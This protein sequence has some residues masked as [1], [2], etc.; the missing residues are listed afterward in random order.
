MPLN[1]MQLGLA[2]LQEEEEAA[3][4]GLDVDLTHHL[5]AGLLQDMHMRTP[6][7][8]TGSAAAA[9]LFKPKAA[10]AATATVA[11]APQH[12]RADGLFKAADVARPAPLLPSQRGA[13]ASPTRS[14]SASTSTS[15]A[16]SAPAAPASGSGDGAGLKSEATAAA[17]AAATRGKRAASPS[18]SDA[19]GVAEDQD[20][21]AAAS[22][23]NSSGGSSSGGSSVT[24]SEAASKSDPGLVGL[25]VSTSPAVVGIASFPQRTQAQQRKN[26]QRVQQAQ[27]PATAAPPPGTASDV[28]RLPSASASASAYASAAP[29][30]ASSAL[31]SPSPSPSAS[32]SLS[33]HSSFNRSRLAAAERA[34]HLQ[35]IATACERL[36]HLSNDTLSLERLRAGKLALRRE[37][38]PLAATVCDA[39][40]LLRAQASAKGVAIRMQLANELHAV[41]AAPAAGTSSASSAASLTPSPAAAPATAP[42][43]VPFVDVESACVLMD[44]GRI[45][46]AISNIVS[47]ALRF[48]E[49]GDAITVHCAL[50][51]LAAVPAALADA[52][53]S[54]GIRIDGFPAITQGLQGTDDGLNS[55]ISS[56]SSGACC[57][58]LLGRASR[59]VGLRRRRGGGAGT[60]ESAGNWL[61][62]A[63][64]TQTDGK[65]AGA[66]AAAAAADAT[67]A[68]VGRPVQVIVSVTD[69]GPGIPA[70]DL[71]NLFVPFS[72]ASAPAAS[73]A[74]RAGKLA[75]SG[76]AAVSAGSAHTEGGA[77]GG[78]KASPLAGVSGQF[79]SA[80]T[81]GL[82]LAL[83][84]EFLRLHGGDL[85]VLSTVGQGCTF[86]LSFPSIVL[87]PPAGHAAAVAA[88]AA[89]S[90]AASASTAAA[91]TAS[92]A[93]AD[94]RCVPASTTT[95]APLD[96]AA[97]N[98]EADGGSCSGSAAAGCAGDLVPSRAVSNG[99]DTEAGT[100]ATPVAPGA[101]SLSTSAS[102]AS[103]APAARALLL[104]SAPV[105]A[106][107]NGIASTSHKG[108]EAAPSSLCAA[109]AGCATAAAIPQAVSAC[110]PPPPADAAAAD[111]SASSSA[112]SAPAGSSV[113]DAAAGSASLLSSATVSTAASTST[114]AA[115]SPRAVAASGVTGNATDGGTA[116]AAAPVL[117]RPGSFTFMARRGLS[118][119]SGADGSGA[120][121]SA[122]Q[123]QL[124]AALQR[125]RI[126]VVEDD[127]ASRVLLARLL[128]L[129]GAPA[130]RVDTAEDGA[131]ALDAAASAAASGDPYTV[132]FA[133]RH[134]PHVTGDAMAR[135][136]RS[137]GFVGIIIAV[138][139][140]A[141][142]AEQR[143]FLAAGAN[144]CVSKPLTKAS[145]AETLRQLLC[146]EPPPPPATA[147]P[148]PAPASS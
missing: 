107:V 100:I 57:S 142:E 114:S 14:A 75:A 82:G 38:A 53:S 89:A 90:A 81:S 80:G 58:G 29:S 143:L 60:A 148:A 21:Q 47:N 134:M 67:A 42:S 144:Q 68:P 147:A 140:D 18:A 66:A 12:A 71:A 118:S 79:S 109:A 64:Q 65:G 19:T 10:S 137:R 113:A 33:P 117:S 83:A 123:A 105:P 122:L 54:G 16:A 98:S 4:A 39:I 41:P 127:G 2:L 24:G 126:L 59:A 145:V 116:V 28:A 72:Q 112:R 15:A 119:G 93:T 45:V 20:P 92:A 132:I 99:V 3:A 26:T 50:R 94:E 131:R 74:S 125:H 102:T 13:S 77:G 129:L 96:A 130:G 6:Q 138:S 121:S 139:G 85:S 136:L 101:A 31:P 11:A 56:S 25:R 86:T 69:Q 36:V 46:G 22:A 55:R 104:E 52:V 5:S 76:A 63:F 110:P 103:G 61:I 84:R 95:V 128:R 91:A 48:S 135:T 40:A 88:T 44:V 1:S 124:S 62:A 27:R 34:L 43:S 133:D 141:L 30:L 78:G 17:A 108:D 120:L 9:A 111:A 7:G 37:P 35:A 115:A 70:A 146:P 73:N 32:P 49:S 51:P 87:T 97:C 23:Y 8:S 106:S